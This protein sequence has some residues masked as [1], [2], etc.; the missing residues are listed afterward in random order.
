MKK[1]FLFVVGLL[2]YTS[3]FASVKIDTIYYDLDNVNYTA[4]VVNNSAYDYAGQR[5]KVIPASVVYNDHDYAVTAIG[6]YAFRGVKLG[7]ISLPEGLESIGIEAFENCNFSALPK[8]PSTLKTIGNYA[9]YNNPNATGTV[10]IPV[11][12]E[13]IGDYAF[14]QL[15]GLD[16]FDIQNANLKTIGQYAFAYTKAQNGQVTIPASITSIGLQA[17]NHVTYLSRVNILATTPPTVN[18]SGLFSDHNNMRPN[19]YV[20]EE[21][22]DTYKTQ[23]SSY[24]ASLIFVNATYTVT[25]KN[26]D[27]TT[28][29][30]GPWQ[31]GAIPY[32][33]DRKGKPSTAEYS[34]FFD[35]W[36]R[37]STQEKGVV[38]VT[39]DETYIATYSQQ[40]RLYTITFKDGE[41]TLQT[42]QIGYNQ[43]AEYLGEN[44]TKENL[45]FAGWSPALTTVTEDATY[46]AVFK[47]RIIFNDEWGHEWQNSLWEVGATPSYSGATPTHDADVQ[48]TYAFKAWPTISAATQNATYTAVF[49]RTLQKYNIVFKV[50]KEYNETVVQQEQ[51]EYGT[52]PEYKGD[53]LDYEEAGRMYHHTG[54]NPAIHVVNGAETYIATFTSKPLYIVNFYDCNKITIL[55]TQ[56]VE[57]GNDATAPTESK[58]AG[59]IITGWDI[60]FTN[61]QSNLN[62]FAECTLETYT[63]TLIAEN[64]TIAVTDEDK[65]PV[66]VSQPIAYGTMLTLV[67]TGNEGFVFDK[68]SDGKTENTRQISVLSDTTFTALFKVRMSQVTVV[69]EHG[70]VVAKDAAENVVD[71][72]EKIAYGTLLYLTAMPDEGYELDSWTNY[73]PETGLTVKDNITVT[74]NFKK[75]TFVLTLV[76]EHGNIIIENDNVNPNAV[77]YGTVVYLKAMPDE[78][79]ELD[80]W[81]NYNPETG[82][83]VMENVTVTATFKQKEQGIE[84]I[85]TGEKAAKVL[86]DG[87]IYILRDGKIFNATGAEVR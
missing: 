60:A 12:V 74:A 37:E 32:C 6:D 21:A 1:L 63:V 55:K 64:G 75:L 40:P 56:T 86:I 53:A 62:V 61:V 47:A 7:R 35:G 9:F 82:L 43:M 13:S 34:Y 83:T 65:K 14:Y 33:N 38:P 58:E 41:T 10:V 66:D 5:P 68:W 18:L 46:T 30:S 59:S 22:L 48:Y 57:E 39:S 31:Y 29:C 36:Q 16:G 67:A 73:N 42:R 49:D 2:T 81:T 51:L 19:L 54:W 72:S 69:A 25:F 45:E 50:V 44:P 26:H 78:G 28:A 70:S 85:L 24:G 52:M 76:A 15:E 80:S 11:N 87:Q 84:N 71:L 79:Y 77:E 23:W 4:T 27:G 17:F 20:P 3:L 8:L